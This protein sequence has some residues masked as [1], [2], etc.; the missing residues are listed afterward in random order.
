MSNLKK[1][2]WFLNL[3][4]L[5]LRGCTVTF[6]FTVYCGKFQIYTILEHSYDEPSCMY[7]PI[8]TNIITRSILLL[9]CISILANAYLIG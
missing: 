4:T 9:D 1:I 5:L 8:S 7:H 2:T 3:E 6:L